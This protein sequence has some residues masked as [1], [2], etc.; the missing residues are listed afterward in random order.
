MLTSESLYGPNLSPMNPLLQPGIAD[1]ENRGGF[2]GCQQFLHG[3]L[4]RLGAPNE[5]QQG[6]WVCREYVFR[7]GLTKA[8]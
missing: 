4:R 8:T 3:D 6:G 1:A 2:A 5:S 7:L